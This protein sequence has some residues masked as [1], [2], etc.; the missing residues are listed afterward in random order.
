MSDTDDSPNRIPFSFR[1]PLPLYRRMEK[2]AAALQMNVSTFICCALRHALGSPEEL[3]K[4][5]SSLEP[6]H[7]P[8]TAP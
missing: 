4:A 2:H 5:L 1:C 3:E 6:G 7:H 8:D